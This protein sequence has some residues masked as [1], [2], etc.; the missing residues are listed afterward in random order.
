VLARQGERKIQ[1][2][3][4]AGNPFTKGSAFARISRVGDTLTYRVLDLLSGAE[5]RTFT[6][7]VIRVTDTEIVRS[8]GVVS[9]LLGN[10]RRTR[11]GYVFS[12]N[13]LVPSEFAVGKRWRTRFDVTT[14]EGVV[15]QSEQRI[16]IT[17]RETVKVP[18][19][20]FNAF[21]LE[22]GGY[23]SNPLG[24]AESEV[25]RWYVPAF[26]WPVA[27]DELRRRAGKVIFTQRLE[28][29]SYKL[30][31]LSAMASGASASGP[32]GPVTSPA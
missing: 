22:G 28:L 8:T 1:I 21:R 15:F 26:Q 5:R 23:S 24:A 12:P 14:P 6:D 27:R 13:Q 9:D 29:V 32:D 3:S 7:T 16:R 19:G 31:S 17:A 4:Q 2:A 11:D 10:R 18:A 30:A 20:S 25:T